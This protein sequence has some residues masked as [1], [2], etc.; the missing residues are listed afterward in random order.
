MMSLRKQLSVTYTLFISIALA[1]LS[2]VINNYASSLFAEFAK[3]KIEERSVEIVRSVSD[4]YDPF[5]DS[6]DITTLEA[7]GMYFTHE[8]Y[9]ITVTDARGAV[10]W[11]AY[12]CDMAECALVIN[13]IAVRM[14]NEYNLNGTLRQETYPVLFH[15]RQV[16]TVS[17]ETYGPFFYSEAELQFLSS[18]NKLLLASSVFFIA[19]SILLSLFLATTIAKPVQAAAQAARSIADGNLTVRLNVGRTGELAELSAS[20]NTLAA[21]LQEAERR[22]EQLVQDVAHELRTPIT[23]LQGN[24]EAM[25]DGVW[26]AT[27]E[28]LASCHEEVVRLTQLVEDLQL[29][30]NLEWEKITLDKSDFDLAQ[31]LEMTAEQFRPVAREK[32]IT[33]QLDTLPCPIFADYNRLKQVFINL[34]SNAVKYTDRG[35]ITIKARKTSEACEITVADT[36]IGI[37]ADELPHVFERLYRS[38]KSRSRGT[39]GSGIGLTIARTIVKA[40]GGT[41]SAESSAGNG[42][43]FRVVL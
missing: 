32:N 40:H 26:Q 8:G 10:A 18:L 15:G 36:G 12:I 38:D 19:V 34:L 17:I 14:G 23:C 16:G 5:T 35:S 30:T 27:P 42:S 3:D 6:F 9:I 2:L 4:L 13:T 39:G 1:A 41:I 43:V 24:I 31:L 22:Q 11:D 29:L 20:L 28:R 21:E 33:I 37:S 25:I 7:L